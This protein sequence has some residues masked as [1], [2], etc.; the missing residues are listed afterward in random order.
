MNSS[1]G[2]S[3]AELLVDRDGE[4]PAS[5]RDRVMEACLNELKLSLAGP[6]LGE[7]R[8]GCYIRF[9]IARHHRRSVF[10]EHLCFDRGA[11]HLLFLKSR[12]EIRRASLA[13]LPS[14]SGV[15]AWPQIMS[16]ASLSKSS[17]VLTPTR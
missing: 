17:L 16:I 7:W 10:E 1:L 3:L 12:F 11:D 8:Q 4:L 5:D 15:V 13:M 9:A 6:P 14:C 2:C